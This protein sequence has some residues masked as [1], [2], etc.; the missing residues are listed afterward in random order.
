M[1]G[2]AGLALA[3]RLRTRAPEL[4]V[5]LFEASDRPGGK[6]R[7][8]RIAFDD[9]RFIVESGP[10]AILAQKPWALRPDRRARAERSVDPDQPYAELNRNPEVRSPDRSARRRRVSRADADLALRAVRSAL[11]AGQIRAALDFVTRPRAAMAT[12]RS[13]RS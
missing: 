3:E 2:I 9:G 6:I 7:T 11:P 8:E 4:T 10:D 5:R 13:A 12:S 1:A